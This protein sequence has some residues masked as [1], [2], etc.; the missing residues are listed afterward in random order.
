MS[1][2][3]AATGT[4]AAAVRRV[5]ILAALDRELARLRGRMS[6]IRKV[7]EGSLRAD[8]GRLAGVPVVLGST[9]DGASN[10]ARGARALLDRFPVAAVVIVGVSGALSPR[11]E[12]GSLLVAREVLEMDR[13]APPPDPDWVRRALRDTGAVAARFLCTP[14]ILCTARSK[15]DALAGLPPGAVAAVDL[16]TAAFARAA[17]DRGL[18]Y[19]ALRAISDLAEESLPLDFNLLRDASGAV[20]N[21]R[22]AR[23]VLGRP[24]LVLPL[25]RLRGR[26]GLCAERLAGAASALLAGA[27]P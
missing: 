23:A 24:S 22:V 19:V 16:E 1:Q 12:A 17:A 11:L 26:C 25:W 9:G 13:P 8:V 10:A 6:G 14:G 7:R 21:L 20:D 5:A 27:L 15:A 18:P 2:A 3:L 4:E